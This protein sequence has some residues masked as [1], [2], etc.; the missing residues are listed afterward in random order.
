MFFIKLS[1]MKHCS[2]YNHRTVCSSPIAANVYESLHSGVARAFPGGRL[3][4]PESQ[5]EEE[6]ENSL[7]KNKKKMIKIWGKMR[8]VELLPTRD[9]EAGYGP[10][11]SY[12][13]VKPVD[14]VK[15]L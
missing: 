9:C 4:N 14:I 8:K 11:P 6:N 10:V 5:N 15:L 13:L 12:S 3:A 2:S 1:T 7:R